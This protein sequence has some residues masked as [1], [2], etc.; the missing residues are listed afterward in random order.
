[1]VLVVIRVTDFDLCT[2]V[3][4]ATSLAWLLS[5]WE[6]IRCWEYFVTSNLKWD[7]NQTLY[8]APLFF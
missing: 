1:M 5:K 6:R 8:L 3:S 4:L 7:T 2:A